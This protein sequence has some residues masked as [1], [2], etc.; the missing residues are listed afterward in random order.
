MGPHRSD[1]GIQ[2]S[3]LITIEPRSA[4]QLVPGTVLVS[5]LSPQTPRCGEIGGG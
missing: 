5:G 2:I 4:S 1:N 3:T